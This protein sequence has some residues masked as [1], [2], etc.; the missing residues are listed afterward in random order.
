MA[1]P[2]DAESGSLS[3]ELQVAGSV[4]LN[5][6]NYVVSGPNFAKSGSLDVSNSATVSGIVGGI[7]I[8]T[9]YTLTLDSKSVSTPVTQ[10]GGS[11]AFNIPGP[12]IT[13][14]SVHLTCHEAPLVVAAATAAP[15]PPA[16]YFG[17][18]VLLLALGALATS[19]PSARRR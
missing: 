9:G 15:I 7:P 1:T 14:L 12:G 6:V 17:L 13:P 2:S 5:T 16:A 18:G 10:C 11:A 8:G 4:Q 19:L 3:F